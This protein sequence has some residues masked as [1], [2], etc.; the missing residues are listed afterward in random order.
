MHTATLSRATQS[1]IGSDR[2]SAR[3]PRSMY[4]YTRKLQETRS[5]THN[6]CTNLRNLNKRW[7]TKI[8]NQ[9]KQV[10]TEIKR[11]KIKQEL[12]A[13][14]RLTEIHISQQ[15]INTIESTRS[16]RGRKQRTVLVV[17]QG[18]PCRQSPAISRHC[19]AGVGPASSPPCKTHRVCASQSPT[20][21]DRSH[22]ASHTNTHTHNITILAIPLCLPRVRIRKGTASK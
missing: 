5:R 14:Y 20:I 11:K 9:K 16:L 12:N 19:C 2:T 13:G 15:W 3:V 18:S 7:F 8:Y 1:N 22:P 17:R 21:Q 10:R 4:S 6:S